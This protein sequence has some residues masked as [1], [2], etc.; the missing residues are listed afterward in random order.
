MVLFSFH[1][2]IPD[3]GRQ[4]KSKATGGRFAAGIGNPESLSM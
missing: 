3:R 2:Q 4:A 1:F